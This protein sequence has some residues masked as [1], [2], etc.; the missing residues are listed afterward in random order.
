M[1]KHRTYLQITA[2][3]M[4]TAIAVFVMV[5]A[6]NCNRLPASTQEGFSGGDTLDIAML[7]GPGSFY[8]DED[9]LTGINIEIARI[10]SD[11]TQVPVKIW[12]ITEPAD[13]MNR[14]ESGAFDILAS[15]PLDN[16]IKERFKVSESIFLDRLVLLQLKDSITGENKINSSRDLNGKEIHVASGSSALLRLRNLSDEIGGDITIIEEPELSDELL[17][18]KV[19]AGDLPFAV[20]NE[21]IAKAISEKYPLLSYDSSVSFT[22]FQVWAF[23]PADSAAYLKF[24]NWFENFRNT[25][26]YREIINQF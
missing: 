3:A 26:S 24:N 9:S 18:V 1:Q 14:L 12:P 13:G 10:F 2:Y 5:I 21:K 4:L 19:G 6:Q 22:Q 8:L 11:S 25:D 17:A 7:Y 20:V 16:Y 23:N 15:I